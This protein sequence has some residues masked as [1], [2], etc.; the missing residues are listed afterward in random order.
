MYSLELFPNI[1]FSLPL[2]TILKQFE[3]GSQSWLDGF[4]TEMRY[5]FVKSHQPTI[6]CPAGGHGHTWTSLTA[7]PGMAGSPQGV[8]PGMAGSPQ[9]IIPGMAGS[10]QGVITTYRITTKC[11]PLI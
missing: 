5:L 7:R 9:G 6:L 4:F 11:I 8:I 10:P 1:I 2:P 3:L